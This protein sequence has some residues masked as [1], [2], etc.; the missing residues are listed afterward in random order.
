MS[1]VAFYFRFIGSITLLFSNG[2]NVLRDYELFKGEEKLI[3]RAENA[4]ASN[5]LLSF[6]YDGT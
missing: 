5:H 6:V 1:M 3:K 2:F 4:L